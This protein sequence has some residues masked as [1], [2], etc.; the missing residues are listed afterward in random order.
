MKRYFGGDVFML[1]GVDVLSSSRSEVGLSSPF[2]PQPSTADNYNALSVVSYVVHPAASCTS[3]QQTHR[4]ASKARDANECSL[5]SVN[6]R[7][8]YKLQ[9]AGLVW[10]HHHH[11]HQQQLQ[12]QLPSHKMPTE[13]LATN[14]EDGCE[15]VAGNGAK[16]FINHGTLCGESRAYILLRPF[17]K[18]P[19]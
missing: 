8:L 19:V 2:R 18:S 12:R 9:P 13:A 14:P 10:R 17:S 3:T 4:Q 6:R 1:C 5:Y 15:S 16:A 11:Q 7:L